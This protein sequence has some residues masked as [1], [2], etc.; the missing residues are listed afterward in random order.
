[1][2]RLKC[3]TFG[4]VAILILGNWQESI[5]DP[6]ALQGEWEIVSVVRQGTTDAAPVGH[7]IRFAGNEVHFEAAD[8][9]LNFPQ[10]LQAFNDANR[11]IP[12]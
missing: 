1:M 3:V 5:D 2:L 7:T 11:R 8:G 12:S 10:V 4:L 6:A 9:R